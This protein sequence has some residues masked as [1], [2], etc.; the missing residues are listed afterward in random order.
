VT[1]KY[2]LVF[3][4]LCWLVSGPMICHADPATPDGQELPGQSQGQ[5]KDKDKMELPA[6][7]QDRSL[8]QMIQLH[9]KALAYDVTVGKLPVRDTKGKV[10]AQVVYTAYITPGTPHR[11][12]TFAFNGGPGASSVFLNMGAIGPRSVKFGEQGDSP[13]ML[14]I[15]DNPNTWLDM[16][17]LVFIDPVGTGFSRSQEDADKSKKDFYSAQADIDYLSRVVYDWLVKY[18]RLTSPKYV[19]GES[20]GGYRAPRIALKLQTDLGVGIS[21]V[22][23]VS[24]YLDPAAVGVEDALSPLPW[25]INLPSMAAANF[26]RTGPVTPEKMAAVEQYDRT[27]FVTDFL[28][29]T[30]DAQAVGRIVTKVAEYTG[31]DPAL[32]ARRQGRIDVETFLREFHRGEHQIGSVYDPNVTSYDPFPGSLR[33]RGGDPILNA[34]I[35]PLTSAMVDFIT[36]E[37]GWKTEAR[38]EALSEAVNSAWVQGDTNDRPVSDLRRAVANDPKM[39]VLI[40]HGYDDLACP[41]FTSRLVIDQL[42]DFGEPNR[43][44]LAVFP[45]GHMFYA[46]PASNA[47]FKDAARPLFSR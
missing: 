35:A 15:G 19:I 46:R 9:G 41:Y 8:H 26:E 10:I 20:Y 39:G 17:D 27:Q 36:R 12:V 31:L 22:V 14:E 37:V 44:R 32:V 25:M 33:L 5:D 18:G 24:P 47:A 3:A 28:A 29:G 11:P 30:A 42:P 16:T 2:P 13:S 40:A 21:G 4:T 43:V 1:P 7:P 34:A 23:M 45:G 38:Y 6:L